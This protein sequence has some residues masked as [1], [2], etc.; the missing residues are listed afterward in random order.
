LSA[1]AVFLLLA[2]PLMPT[3]FLL[4]AA[5]FL[6]VL[7]D[8]YTILLHSPTRVCFLKMLEDPT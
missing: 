5:G 1:A 4:A 8:A 7:A 2:V 6:L 3:C